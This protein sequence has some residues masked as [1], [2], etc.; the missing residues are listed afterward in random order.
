MARM[1]G[2]R[3]CRGQGAGVFT[4]NAKHVSPSVSHS[5]AARKGGISTCLIIAMPVHAA[6]HLF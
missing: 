6:D 1:F 4:T 3:G 5:T 2:G